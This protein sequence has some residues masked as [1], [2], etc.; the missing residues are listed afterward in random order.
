VWLPR[1]RAGQL[2]DDLHAIQLLAK[3]G[4]TDT[5]REELRTG[6]GSKEPVTR[7]NAIAALVAIGDADTAR[8]ALPALLRDDHPVVRRRAA[9]AAWDLEAV[10]AMPVL[11]D[12]LAVETDEV[13]RQTL[14]QVLVR[15]IPDDQVVDILE[16]LPPLLRLDVRWV[17]EDRWSAAEQLHRLSEAPAFD[18]DWCRE[19]LD[20]ADATQWGGDEL[21]LLVGL[22]VTRHYY[23]LASHEQLRTIAARYPRDVWAEGLKHVAT[24]EDLFDLAVLAPLPDQ[25][26][27]ETAAAAVNPAARPA[28]NQYLELRRSSPGS[29]ATRSHPRPQP[30]PR[31]SLGDLVDAGDLQQ[32][33]RRS[34][35]PSDLASLTEPQQTALAELV[36]NA[37]HEWAAAPEPPDETAWRAAPARFA[38]P[39]GMRWAEWSAALDLPLDRTA[40]LRL[41]GA[42]IYLS[43]VD[44]WV[45]H[46]FDPAWQDDLAAG[47]AAWPG[48]ALDHGVSVVLTPWSAKLTAAFAEACFANGADDHTKQHCV[49][50]LAAN[51]QHRVLQ[52]LRTAGDDPLVDDGLVRAGDCAAE[53]RLLG[54]LLDQDIPLLPELPSELRDHWIAFV[55]CP[56]SIPVL[57]D[58]L[59]QLL[60]AGV[61]SAA[62]AP[63]FAALNQ[64][65]GEAALAH[66]DDLLADAVIEEGPFLWY[67]RQ[68]L[69]DELLE[70]RSRRVLPDT[71][72]E[73]GEL[74]L[75]VLSTPG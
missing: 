42:P 70:Q 18:E 5:L 44:R 29:Q 67:R 69:V 63:V 38:P 52:Q 19:I 26:L 66:Y 68:E 3:A 74:R 15:L 56:G 55:H 75:T 58:V 59:R 39:T 12:Q 48:P 73:L 33:L 61:D 10:D 65:A 54:S 71:L 72:R 32:L 1:D 22:I 31:P 36:A 41:A 35:T 60:R 40:W 43:D 28:V 16:S 46:R 47:V 27:L 11:K 4:V 49:R 6:C 9:A 53:D 30:A 20:N 2:I 50:Q 62:L 37:L 24:V 8:E 25:E 57:V 64:G 21:R 14:S 7:G 34:P 45:R 13:A 23:T 17:L 51:R